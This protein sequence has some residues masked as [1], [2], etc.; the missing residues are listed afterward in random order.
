MVIQ[1]TW[2]PHL[3]AEAASN[4][5]DKILTGDG[6]DGLFG[7]S[8]PTYDMI[9]RL[10]KWGEKRANCDAIARM[11]RFPLRF[12]LDFSRRLAGKVGY[13]NLARQLSSLEPY[14][15]SDLVSYVAAG[16]ESRSSDIFGIFGKPHRW[17]SDRADLF[18]SFWRTDCE[19]DEFASLAMDLSFETYTVN[20]VIFKTELAGRYFGLVAKS[21]YLAPEVICRAMGIPLHHRR[22][23]AALYSVAEELFGSDEFMEGIRRKKHG[24]SYDI[25]N[26]LPELITQLNSLFDNQ[27]LVDWLCID[28]L[29]RKRLLSTLTRQL[30]HP[31]RIWAIFCLG[32]WVT[33]NILK[34]SR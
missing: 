7:V 29:G 11:C 26:L 2:R 25:R 13:E 30:G 12:G 3:I 16:Q 33:H 15:F 5:T 18:R 24:F 28:A 34:H 4:E 8:Q 27:Q 22:N 9:L 14:G 21:A 1:P 17:H 20:G 6:A 23:K 31:M 32:T 19:I 10:Q